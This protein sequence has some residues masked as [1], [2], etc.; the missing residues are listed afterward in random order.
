MLECS[1]LGG[2]TQPWE[3]EKVAKPLKTNYY[4][5]SQVRDK[6]RPIRAARWRGGRE[7]SGRSKVE[8]NRWSACANLNRG[9]A[10]G[11]KS[12]NTITIILLV[13]V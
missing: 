9:G 8:P 1:D 11:T 2:E 4:S 13:G 7:K 12:S 5:Y 3:L 10:T 6:N